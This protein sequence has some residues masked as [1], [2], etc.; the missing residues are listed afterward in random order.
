MIKTFYAFGK[1]AADI[2]EY[3]EYFTAWSNPFSGRKCE[4]SI[5]LIADIK[6][7]MLCSSLSQ[8]IF[9]SKRLDQYLFR[10]LASA[11]ATSLVPSLY[12]YNDPKELGDNV[13]KFYDKLKRCIQA[14]ESIY[15]QFLDVKVFLAQIIQELQKAIRNV[16]FK[17][18]LLFTIRIDGKYIGEI[19]VIREILEDEAYSKYKRSKKAEFIGYDKVCAVTYQ[20]VPE[21]WGRVDT[22]GFTVDEESFL[23]GGF[24]ASDAYKMF[25]VSSTAVPILEG[26][27]RLILDK[28]SYGFYGMKYFV[29]PH[30]LRASTEV[31]AEVVQTFLDKSTK[32]KTLEGQTGGIIANEKIIEEICDSDELSQPGIYYDIFFYQPNNAQFLIKL[33]IAD[34]LPSRFRFIQEV[35]RHLE[36]QYQPITRIVIPAKGKTPEKTIPYEVKIAN[37]KE[38]FS[39]TVQKKVLFHPMFFKVLESIFHGTPLSEEQILR[40]FLDQVIHAFKNQPSL[41]YAFAQDVKRTFVTYQYFFRLGLFS[42]LPSMTYSQLTP[43]VGLTREAFVSQHSDFFVKY[44]VVESAF[45]AGCLVEKLLAKQRKKLNSEPFR[46]YLYNLNLDQLK[47]QKVLTKLQSKLSDYA[48]DISDYERRE[49]EA[50]L[51]LILPNLLS[52]DTTVSKTKIS[53]AFAMGMIMQKEFSKEAWRQSKLKNNQNQDTDI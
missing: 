22:L 10:E 34:V 14:N 21:V 36:A 4:E 13:L 7:K 32:P 8:E 38:Y 17:G 23:R 25:P 27:G 30:F 2:E 11:R 50:L 16:S 6:E 41:P 20:Q 42:S 15:A 28:L 49:N 26:S 5:V 43:T 24:S 19:P 39:D 44:P 1:A 33:H 31:R 29:L 9:N 37:I 35:K 52:V 18:N 53:Y 46:K 51:A 12:L 3:V 45:Y 47:L 40:T 48:K